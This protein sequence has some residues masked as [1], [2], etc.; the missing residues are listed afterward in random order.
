MQ[1][2]R[3]DYAVCCGWLVCCNFVT[4]TM[5]AAEMVLPAPADVP[6]GDEQANRYWLTPNGDRLGYDPN[7]R[8][9]LCP[10]CR[11]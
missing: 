1:C 9:V 4:C 3:T 5:L 7:V 8:N 6:F 11:S 2:L 10:S